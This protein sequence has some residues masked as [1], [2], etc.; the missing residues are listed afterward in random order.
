MTQS[1]TRWMSGTIFKK[2]KPASFVDRIKANP[3][4]QKHVKPKI[5][6]ACFDLKPYIR[7]AKMVWTRVLKG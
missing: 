4:I 7:H 6:A 5:L 1:I 3:E 2:G